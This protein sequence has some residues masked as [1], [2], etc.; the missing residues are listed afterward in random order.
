MN[1]SQAVDA[2]KDKFD[3]IPV[4]LFER[5]AD[6][7]NSEYGRSLDGDGYLTHI[8]GGQL[9]CNY[10]GN[11]NEV[12]L[13]ARYVSDEYGD[14]I[15]GLEPGDG[16]RPAEHPDEGFW[17]AEKTYCASCERVGEGAHR[18]A[19]VF[20]WP[21]NEG[22]LY[23]DSFGFF[24][25]TNTGEPERLEHLEDAGFCVFTCEDMTG[26]LIGVDGQGAQDR[27]EELYDLLELTWHDI[28]KEMA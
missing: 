26:V 5:A 22:L 8:A 16:L 4:A 18:R 10:C 3:A 20:A 11:N 13:F 23:W 28:P 7:F 6:N 27:W 17:V 14:V 2:F 9:T 25:D 1:K 12:E 15:R 19:A 24:K 21:V